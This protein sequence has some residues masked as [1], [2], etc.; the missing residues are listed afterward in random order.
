MKQLK[1][2]A[3][4]DANDPKTTFGL[5][6][7]Q[8]PWVRFLTHHPTFEMLQKRTSHCSGRKPKLVRQT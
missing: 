4:S 5:I 3:Q 6:G 2:A 7:I 1:C 8:R